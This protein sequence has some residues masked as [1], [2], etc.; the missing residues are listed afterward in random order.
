MKPVC[1]QAYVLMN[2]AS[3]VATVYGPRM[4]PIYGTYQQG[5]YMSQWKLKLR[6]FDSFL[7]DP[8]ILKN[9]DAVPSH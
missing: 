8:G 9:S 1:D 6:K 5:S 2:P 7:S 4:S 3:Y